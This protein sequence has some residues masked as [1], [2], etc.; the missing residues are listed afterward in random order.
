MNNLQQ[1]LLP[2]ISLFFCG[3]LGANELAA[4]TI[5]NTFVNITAYANILGLT[6]AGDTLF[7]Q[8]RRIKFGKI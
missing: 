7:P 3:H 4:V 5:A 6:S 1:V 2:V 8:V